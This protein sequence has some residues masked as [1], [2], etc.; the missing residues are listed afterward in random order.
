MQSLMT[1]MISSPGG[2]FLFLFFLFVTL[3]LIP[4]KAELRAALPLT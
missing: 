2:F 3:M 1:A 4:Q